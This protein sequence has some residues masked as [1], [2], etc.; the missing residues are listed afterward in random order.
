MLRLIRRG[1]LAKY[2]LPQYLNHDMFVSYFAVDRFQR[3][4][5]TSTRAENT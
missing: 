2:M 4:Y 5:L 1:L 3:A